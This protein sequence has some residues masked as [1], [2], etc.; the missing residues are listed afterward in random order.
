MTSSAA[1]VQSGQRLPCSTNTISPHRNCR[2][3]FG[4]SLHPGNTCSRGWQ[5]SHPTPAQTHICSASL[6]HTAPTGG[7]GLDLSD[8]PGRI[9]PLGVPPAPCGKPRGQ[10]WGAPHGITMGTWGTRN[11]CW[12][13]LVQNFFNQIQGSASNSESSVPWKFNPSAE[14]EH[15]EKAAKPTNLNFQSEGS[16][17]FLVS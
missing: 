14:A 8:C 9:S 16:K 10:S 11:S 1:A 2:L 3:I 7:L 12:R 5:P 15:R 6:Q 13:F 4:G 17:S